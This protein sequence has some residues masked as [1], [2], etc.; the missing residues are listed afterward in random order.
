LGG[1]IRHKKENH[2]YVLTISSISGLLNIISLINGYL[3]TPKLHQFNN[4][5]NWIN[6]HTGK[7]IM[8]NSVDTSP[9]LENA[10]LA[11]FIDAD[12]LRGLKLY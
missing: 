5:I 6:S 8:I 10:W 12:C 9:I 1:T 7:S 3:R 11:G 4:L 2:A